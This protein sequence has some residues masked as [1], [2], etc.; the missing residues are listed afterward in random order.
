MPKTRKADP[1]LHAWNEE[2]MKKAVEAHLYGMPLRAAA[3]VYNVK[4]STLSRYA[5]A[6]RDRTDEAK[7]ESS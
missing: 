5:T 4:R 2:D 7:E 3:E 6:F 1:S